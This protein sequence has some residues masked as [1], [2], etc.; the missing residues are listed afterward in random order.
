MYEDNREIIANDPTTHPPINVLLDDATVAEVIDRCPD[1]LWM[2]PGGFT[3]NGEIKASRYC[4][5]KAALVTKKDVEFYC[6]WR[7]WYYL[8]GDEVI[9]FLPERGKI[10]VNCSVREKVKTTKAK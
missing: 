1:K 6:S 5:G 4:Q 2:W 8:G 9:G 3:K 10:A 7:A